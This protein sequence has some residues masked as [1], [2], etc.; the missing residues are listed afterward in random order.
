MNGI[1]NLFIDSV[2]QPTCKYYHGIFS[3]NTLPD[4]LIELDRFSVV[5]NL[6]KYSE[7]GSH[8]VCII[9]LPHL[10]LYIDSFG[11][12]SIISEITKF[13]SRLNKPVSY[14]TIQLQHLKSSFCGFYCIL[15]VLFYDKPPILQPVLKFDDSNLLINDEL[16]IVYIKNLLK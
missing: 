7:V 10:V 13:L 2:L 15:F 12:P 1:S 14:N 4:R 11:M 5:C 8:F 16:C 9:S 6:S 3:A